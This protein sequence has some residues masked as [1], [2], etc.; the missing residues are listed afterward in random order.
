MNALA[1][2][3]FT[4]SARALP[5]LIFERHQSTG[6]EG[7]LEVVKTP[8]ACVPLSI[9]ASMTSV[10][11][12]YL[13][14]AAAVAKRTPSIAGKCA[15]SF[16]ASGETGAAAAMAIPLLNGGSCARMGRAGQSLFSATSPSS[17]NPPLSIKTNGFTSISEIAAPASMANCERP[18]SA[19][20]RA[21]RS[22]AGL[23]R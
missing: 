20:T 19:F 10:R 3:E 22:S 12:A 17:A 6:A 8:A 4:T 21:A 11:P 18:I 5:P 14:P 13:M 2:P 23:P 1:L 16:G 7:H 15:N 9:N